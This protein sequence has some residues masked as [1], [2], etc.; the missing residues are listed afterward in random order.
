[1]Q[2]FEQK[3]A[4]CRYLRKKPGADIW[5]LCSSISSRVVLYTD[6]AY[7]FAHSGWRETWTL[8]I[9]N[10][11][12]KITEAHAMYFYNNK[13][14]VCFLHPTSAK[15]FKLIWVLF[16]LQRCMYWER[17]WFRAK[18]LD[19]VTNFVQIVLEACDIPLMDADCGYPTST[20]C[21]PLR[22]DKVQHAAFF[23]KPLQL[24][25]AVCCEELWQSLVCIHV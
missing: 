20:T 22:S 12:Y 7:I 24:M 6:E 25:H 9:Q 5:R 21:L 23:R 16:I 19:K 1:M 4:W 10:S 18:K 11:K 17:P 14:Q 8:A 3:K 2:I 13:E 15:Q